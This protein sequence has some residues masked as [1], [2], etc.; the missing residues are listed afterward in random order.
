[1]GV[2][3]ATRPVTRH[4][5]TAR[6]PRSADQ[7]AD[8]VDE[9]PD[10]ATDDGAVDADELQVTADL[11]LDAVGGVAGVPPGHGR[12][13]HVADLALRALDQLD[14]GRRDPAV[15]PGPQGL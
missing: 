8:G 12:G 13:D 11:E 6:G 15:D 10:Q 4:A 9:Q 5:P 3:T 1:R 7:L 14:R 2:P